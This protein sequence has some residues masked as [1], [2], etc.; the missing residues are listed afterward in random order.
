[1]F[2]RVQHQV[3]PNLSLHAYTSEDGSARKL[4]SR[5]HI[6]RW[7][8]PVDNENSK[9][10]GWRV[11]GPGIDTRGVGRKGLPTT[12]GGLLVHCADHTLRHTGQV[13][14]TAKLLLA[15]RE[16]PAAK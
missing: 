13:V 3:L 2:V 4:F 15:L 10:I 5:F 16:A 6:I 8:V 9:M 14:T 1:M 7:T 11:M 12:V